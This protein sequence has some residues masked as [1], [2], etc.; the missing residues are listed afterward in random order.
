MG[1]AIEIAKLFFR[2]LTPRNLPEEKLF[3]E[4]NNDF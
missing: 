3:E 4:N 1:W 2:F